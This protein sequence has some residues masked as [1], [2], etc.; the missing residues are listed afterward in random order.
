MDAE[1]VERQGVATPGDRN[2]EIECRNRTCTCKVQPLA[3]RAPPTRFRFT[4]DDPCAST[5]RVQSLLLERCVRATKSGPLPKK[6]RSR[7]R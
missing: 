2:V 6:P 3:P 5:E 7:H 4:I 1:C